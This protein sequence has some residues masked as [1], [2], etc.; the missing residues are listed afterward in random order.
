MDET[1]FDITIYRMDPNRPIG[2]IRFIRAAVEARRGYPV[3]LK[4]A[5]AVM[6]GLRDSGQR[7]IIGSVPCRMRSALSMAAKECG[8]ELRDPA[9]ATA[10]YL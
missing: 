7:I 8:V 1:T 6:E 5:K 3:S 10:R 2:C 9:K 4:E